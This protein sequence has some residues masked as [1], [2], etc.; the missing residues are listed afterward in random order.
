MREASGQLDSDNLT[1]GNISA[2]KRKISEGMDLMKNRQKLI[3][4]AYSVDAGWR[5]VDLIRG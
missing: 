1:Q 5:V 2:A 3:K 4:L